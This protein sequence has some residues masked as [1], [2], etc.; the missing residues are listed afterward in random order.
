MF[1]K[2][3]QVYRI[4]S[5]MADMQTV[6]FSLSGHPVS[7]LGAQQ[8]HRAGWASPYGPDSTNPMMRIECNILPC[9]VVLCRESYRDLPASVVRDAVN[10]KL[11][12]IE[13]EEG[14]RPGSRERAEIKDQITFDLMPQA[15]VKHRDTQVMRLGEFLIV[16]AP[17][18]SRAEQVIGHLRDAIGSVPVRRVSTQN[19]MAIVFTDWLRQSCPS[20]HGFAFDADLHLASCD[21]A[22]LAVKATNA[23]VND[24]MHHL[25][26]GCLV[27]RIG[28]RTNS[29]SFT[30]C[31]DLSIK[32]IRPTDMTAERL[33]AIDE[34]DAEAERVATYTLVAGLFD[35]LFKVLF[36]GVLGG[37]ERSD[38]P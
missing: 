31:D 20:N 28:L 3:A 4:T 14:R 22:K 16:D 32:R 37:I 35:D 8:T 10:K 30:L 26:A 18:S 33:D 19:N 27:Q 29:L 38:E 23:D 11:R 12:L 7:E 21:D 6:E 17:T 36:E 15:F 24:I 2:N 5:A 34:E 1:F 25:D 9:Y 13:Q